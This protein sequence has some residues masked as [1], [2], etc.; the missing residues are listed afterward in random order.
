MSA[1]ASQYPRCCPA[2]ATRAGDQDFAAGKAG[3]FPVQ[4]PALV[5]QAQRRVQAGANGGDQ[6]KRIFRHGLIEDASAISNYIAVHKS[7]K[8]Q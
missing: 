5:L 3:R 1:S 8:E 4:P 6:S 2:D 7:G